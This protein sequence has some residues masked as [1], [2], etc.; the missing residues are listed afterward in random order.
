[1]GWFLINS[2]KEYI[3][4]I[5]TKN[6]KIEF[7]NNV[8]EALDYEGRPG[9]GHWSAAND[10]DFIAFHFK[11]EYG[12]KVTTLTPVCEDCVEEESICVDEELELDYEEL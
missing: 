6:S 4:T 7:T 11:D 8:D 12:D 2:D 10:K 3:K 1:M 9:G 5:D